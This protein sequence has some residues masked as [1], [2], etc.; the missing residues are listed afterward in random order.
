LKG[1]EENSFPFEGEGRKLLPLEGEAGAGKKTPSQGRANS[2]PSGG[3]KTRQES[4]FPFRRREDATR[5]LLPLQGE[6]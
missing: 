6:G 3:G 1:R 4:S 5:E 2:F